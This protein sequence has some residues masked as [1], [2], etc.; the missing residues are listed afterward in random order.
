MERTET[1]SGSTGKANNEAEGQKPI[2]VALIGKNSKYKRKKSKGSEKKLNP[3][4][5]GKSLLLVVT[6]SSS[7]EDTQGI[8]IGSLQ[9]ETEACVWK[10]P[11]V[12]EL[13][14]KMCTTMSI[15]S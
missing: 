3:L 11:T 12:G 13:G 1:V 6:L 15:F 8:H 10:L 2:P 7:P 4:W 14:L 9:G 5:G